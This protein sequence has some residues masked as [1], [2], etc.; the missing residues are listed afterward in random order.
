MFQGNAIVGQSGGPT[1][2]I[3]SS[4]CGVVQSC[5]ELGQK[6]PNSKIDKVYGM[7]YGI[8]GFMQDKLI[9]FGA[10]DSAVV[11]GLKTTPGSAL[12]SCRHKVQEADFPIILEQL[13][14]YNIRYYFLAGGNDTM[15]T[16]RRVEE[17]CKKQGYDLR[18]VGVPKTVDNDLFAT[19]HTPGFGSAARY[20]AMSVKQAGVLAR[21]MKKV[22]QYVIFQTIGRDAG[23]LPAAAACA[24]TDPEDAPH[25][26]LVPEIPFEFDKFVAKAQETLDKY[27]FVS[28]VC[29]EGIRDKN[30][31]VVSSLDADGVKIDQEAVLDKFGNQELG[32]MA[33]TS[34]AIALHRMLGKH[35]KRA[36]GKDAPCRGEFQVTE[37]LP[38]CGADRTTELDIQEAWNCGRRAVE[39]ALEGKSGVM[40]TMNRVSN[41]PYK[42]EY[43]TAPLSAVA[44]EA[45]PMPLEYVDAENLYVTKECVEYLKPLVGELPKYVKLF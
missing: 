31:V 2:V 11:E 12:G 19:D 36:D 8:E 34:V 9:D 6:D 14:K 21:D 40:V 22:D 27:G 7:Q 38:M 35:L 15:D 39:L 13:K 1:S 41:D 10:I 45:K 30:G 29:G 42:I 3:N 44:V 23:W 25:I 5:F 17:Y 4:L 32:A 16:I 20:V 26:I 43:E 24:K 28:V 18:G 33:G 37:S